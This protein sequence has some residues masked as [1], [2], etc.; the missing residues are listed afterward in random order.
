MEDIQGVMIKMTLRVFE[1]FAGYGGWTWGLKKI[2]IDFIVVGVSEIDPYPVVCY[3]N[4]HFTVDWAEERPTSENPNAVEYITSVP[5]NYRDI[6]KIDPDELPDFD[7][8]CA[9][10]PCFSEETLVITNR[11]TIPIKYVNIG[12]Y[13]LTHKNRFRKVLKIGNKNVESYNV[14][15]FSGSP[16]IKCTSEHQFYSKKMIKVWNNLRRCSERIFSESCWIEAQH[17][18]CDDFVGYGTWS[19]KYCENCKNLTDEECWLLGRF[20][21]DGNLRGNNHNTISYS[22]G[23]KKENLFKNKIKNSQYNWNKQHKRTAVSYYITDKRFYNL[24]KECGCG[25]LNK[26]IP[27]YI[28]NLPIC[29]LNIFLNGYM[30]G[31]GCF[32][33]NKFCATSVSKI[34]I[35]QLGQIIHRVYRTPYSITYFKRPEKTIIE[36]RIVNQ[37][38]TWTI[39]FD[40][41]HNKLDNSIWL[42]NNVWGRFKSR[43][44]IKMPIR[45]YNLEVEEDNSYTAN[46][47]IV[48]N[49]QSFSVAGLGNGKDDPRGRLFENAIDIM[50][51]KQ[52]R[53]AIY[54]NVKGLVSRRHKEYFEY[55]LKL[56]RDAGYH[57]VWNILNTKDFGIPQNRERVFIICFKNRDECVNF[58]WPKKEELNMF[59]KDILDKDVDEKY[60]LK[61]KQLNRLFNSKDIEKQFSTLDSD[62]A[63]CMTARQFASWRGNFVSDGIQLDVSQIKRE[64]KPRIYENVSRC[65]NT[66]QG[67]GHT[68]LIVASRGRYDSDGNIKQNIEPRSGG[69]T[70]ILTSV[71]KDNYVCTSD[72]DIRIRKLTP[73]ECFRLQGFVCDEIILDGLSDSRL[74]KLAGNGLSIN[75]V[76]KIFKEMFK[77]GYNKDS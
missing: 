77:D 55:I 68:P 32:S 27:H 5:Y 74:Y 6:T 28:I 22:I 13:V 20:V 57:V 71:Q 10:P 24:C 41:K 47:V 40:Y 56:M 44:K 31:D 19:D 62:I 66:A 45:V 76:S 17:L 67:G 16:E 70:N 1:C 46:N 11:G 43:K 69:M 37:H 18:R 8:F 33:N 4:N 52:P 23:F 3:D 51:I 58:E 34:L 50:R 59:L 63:G 12:D 49:C 30:S 35:Y 72:G 14:L 42:N 39:R 65:L 61:E 64:G 73:K 38:D 75:V 2:G 48:H 26:H 60:Y 7:M 53:Y 36:G 21:A 25:A 29:K 54:E 9:S 15:K